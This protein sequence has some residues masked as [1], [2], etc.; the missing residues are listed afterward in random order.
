MDQEV[1]YRIWDTVSQRYV[2]AAA[3]RR[4][5]WTRYTDALRN[6]QGLGAYAPGRFELHTFK[7]TRV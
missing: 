1:V 6:L 2:A 4:T 7:L 3:S 5:I